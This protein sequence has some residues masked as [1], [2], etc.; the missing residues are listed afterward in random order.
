[1][2]EEHGGTPTFPMRRE[3][4][5]GPPA[6]YERLRARCPV[7]KVRLTN[8]QEV[9]A[10]TGHAEARA[11]LT[12]PR[13]SSQTESEGSP[14][15]DDGGPKMNRPAGFFVDMDAPEHT[16]F[17]RLLAGEFTAER[18]ERLRPAIQAAVDG[19][20]DDMLRGR[21]PIDLVEAYALPVP[22]IVICRILGVPY[23]DHEFFQSR[24]RVAVS[25]SRDPQERGAA[26][27]DVRNYLDKLI[28]EKRRQPTDDLIGRLAHGRGGQAAEL[29]HDELLGVS[30]LLLV[31]GHET[32]ANMISLGVATLLSHP[33]Q[34]AALRADPSLLGNT[35]EELLRLHSI[36]DAAT[37]A[38][39]AKADLELAGT[40]IRA[41]DGLLVLGAA[42]DHDPAAY[43]EP[44]TFDIRRPT[45][46]HLGFGA[47]PHQC[48]GKNLARAEL[49]I[50]YRTLLARV[51]DLRLAVAAEDLPIKA[52]AS[53]YGL[54]ALPVTW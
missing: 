5:I 25:Q 31:A 24:T 30:Y 34:L 16:R 29:T 27:Q 15:I 38:R 22:S 51:P 50:A 35:V 1:M 45:A 20:I 11:A 48:L 40:T 41:G 4:L 14:F 44:G 43:P 3:S 39:V 28:S 10:V 47:G 13:V 9:W 19:L 8:G 6:A 23:E 42:A 49:E 36:A 53:V 2:S 18:V 33:A 46:R 12:D 32:T 54:D 17:R 52:D 37:A 21:P 7:A 26:V